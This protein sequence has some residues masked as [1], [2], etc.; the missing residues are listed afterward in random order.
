MFIRLIL[1]H[2]APS[3]VEARISSLTAIITL[4]ILTVSPIHLI[5]NTVICIHEILVAQ[6]AI[7][8]NLIADFTL[9]LQVAESLDEL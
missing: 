6:V 9:P 3:L 5:K 2:W 4:M 1:G 8:T 7:L